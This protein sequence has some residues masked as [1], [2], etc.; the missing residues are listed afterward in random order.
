MAVRPSFRLAVA[1]LA[2]CAELAHGSP[3]SDPTSGRAVFTGA[4]LP[5][6]TSIDLNPAALGLSNVS[7]VYLA[8]TSAIDQL[9]VDLAPF[10][11]GGLA[12]PAARVR[13]VEVSPGA[14]VAFLYHLAGDRGTLGFSA[15][16]NPRESFLAGSQALRYQTLGGG[17]RDWLASA[18]ASIK[19][20]G[21]L[22]FGASL[23]HQNS[24]LRLK[25]ARD[26]A[27]ASTDPARGIGGDCGAGAP[28]GLGDP[29]AT[30]LYNYDVGSKLLS[31][32]NLKVNVG[33]VVQLARDTW[34]GVA[35]HTPPGLAIQTELTGHV[36]I[37]RAP[38]DA[39]DGEAATLHGQSV[40]EIQFPASVDAELRSRLPRELELHVGG[41]WEDTSR[42]VSYDVRAFGTNLPRAG[43]PEWTER[44]RG[45]KDTF[46]FWGGVE[47]IDTGQRWLFGARFGF[48]TAS[49]ADDRLSP[50]TFSPAQAS[51]DLGA[52]WRLSRVMTLQL[53]YGLTYFPRV[54]VTA[55]RFDP[56]AEQTCTASGYSYDNPACAQVRDGY[57]IASANGSYERLQHAF[58][59]GLRYDIQ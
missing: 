50:L 15:R 32:A 48:E 9:H 37:D 56:T 49:V 17:Q 3:R 25:Y 52:Q 55:S 12:S 42:F 47:Q 53:S 6:A 11:A 7:A 24:F 38:R 27:L 58:R 59:L 13:D 36:D 20:T 5:H 33:V 10:A 22:Y 51:I 2:A 19:L 4:S 1:L 16:T 43:I 26:T 41:R 21:D 57:A 44:P 31:T 29:R 28:C 30:E 40:V 18:A 45:M 23:S 14:M 39:V 54:D 8:L 34:L 35:Y 46:A